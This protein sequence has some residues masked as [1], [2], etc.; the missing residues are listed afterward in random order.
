M[1]LEDPFLK[2]LRWGAVSLAGWPL[3]FS[4]QLLAPPLE[5]ETNLHLRKELLSMPFQ[6]V[7][8]QVCTLCCLCSVCVCLPNAS[9][10][11]IVYSCH[12]SN[13]LIRVSLP[14]R[15]ILLSC[16][17][18]EKECSGSHYLFSIG[19]LGHSCMSGSWQWD[20]SRHWHGNKVIK[21]CI[22]WEYSMEA[23][24]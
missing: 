14:P 10:Y 1:T 3:V 21:L 6:A 12:Q 18:V 20:A 22:T 9:Q 17:H 15:V 16:L 24:S 7:C 8:L 2:T 11:S 23:L 19:A 4:H 5:R 13:V